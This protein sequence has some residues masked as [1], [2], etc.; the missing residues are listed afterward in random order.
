LQAGTFLGDVL[1]SAVGKCLRATLRDAVCGPMRTALP[2]AARDAADLTWYGQQDAWWV[3]HYDVWRRAGLVTYRAADDRELDLWAALARSADRA[4]PGNPGSDLRLY[5]VPADVWGSPA[6]VLLAVNGSAE[7]DGRRRQYAL[8]VPAIDDPVAAAAW[9]YGL[10]KDQYARLVRRTGLDVL[11]HLE[12]QAT[13][14][15]TAGLQAQGDLTVIPHAYLADDVTFPPRAR[16]HEVPAA[17]TELLRSTAGGNPH[18]LVADPG[19]CRW[20][21]SIRDPSGLGLGA[22]TA[23]AVVYLLHPEHGGTGI[24]PGSYIIRRQRERSDGPYYQS[25]R[26][27]AD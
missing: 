24:A 25:I 26:L 21:T 7:P 2:G 9:T 4:D 13:I 10:T 27:I 3:G 22:L 17:G 16:W 1:E 20:T 18:T 6:R 8:S 12:R 5:D 14:P 15:V 11:D 19:T 23:T